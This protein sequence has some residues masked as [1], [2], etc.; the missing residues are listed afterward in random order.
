MSTPSIQ[1]MAI[2]AL[3]GGIGAL[4]LGAVTI[5]AMNTPSKSPTMIVP[6]FQ[7]SVVPVSVPAPLDSLLPA[8]SLAPTVTEVTSLGSMSTSPPLIGLD[9][10]NR[11]RSI[12]VSC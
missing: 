8:D 11:R 3:L 1:T 9:D 2:R 10:C 4:S 7:P 12:L 6:P 5:A